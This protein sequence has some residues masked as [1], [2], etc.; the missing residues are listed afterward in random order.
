MADVSAKDQSQ[1]RIVNL[2]ALIFSLIFIPFV[3]DQ[4]MY[5]FFGF[6]I[7]TIFLIHF[8]YFFSD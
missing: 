3:S 5:G 1:E 8:P 6:S 4:P 2:I 7:S